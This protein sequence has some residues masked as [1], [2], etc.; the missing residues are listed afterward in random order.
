MAGGKVLD[1]EAKRILIRGRDRGKLLILSELVQDELITIEEA[2]KR[3]DMN[4]EEFE[5]KAEEAQNDNALNYVVKDKLYRDDEEKWKEA[6]IR[7]WKKGW[8]EGWR[9]SRTETLLDLVQKNKLSVEEAA[10]H[11]CMSV[12]EFNQKVAILQCEGENRL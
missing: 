8:I 9:E 3:V 4:V 1:Y 7:D 10:A 2:A 6:W 5:Y 11:A 12:E